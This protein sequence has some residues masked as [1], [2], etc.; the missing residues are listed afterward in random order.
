MRAWNHMPTLHPIDRLMQGAL[1]D[2]VFPG[3]SLL[4]FQEKNILWEKGYGLAQTVPQKRI[5]K[6]T[7]LFDI[8]SLTKPLCTATLFMKAWEEKKIRLEEPLHK[9]LPSTLPT[10]I[11]LTHL[12]HHTSGLPAW[13]PYYKGLLVEAPGWI[14]D[15]KGKE[16][17]IQQIL[18]EPLLHPTGTKTLYSDLG[19]IL[20]GAILEKIYDAPLDGVFAEKVAKSLGLTHT[21]FN[22]LARHQTLTDANLE[23]FAATEQSGWRNKMILG[24]VHDDHAY[25][26]G[27]VAG[28]AGL[29]STAHEVYQWLLEL[30][31]A[32][33]GKNSF[34]KKETVEHFLSIPTQRNLKEPFFTLGFDTPS[35]PSSSGIHFSPNSVG[36]LGYTGCSFWWDLEQDMGMILLTNRVHPSRD[37]EKIKFFRPRFHDTVIESLR[38]N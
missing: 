35:N 25:L 15:E 29:F 5:L 8:A 30:R 38:L 10:K 34:L 37:N 19:Y 21:F 20:L 11:T 3:A 18:K 4:V 24:E 7:T 6:K 27:G 33:K 1:E 36:H 14:A 28:H 22:P 17:L 23:H 26:M 32:R 13:R 9:F 16:W 2:G 31:Q 12:L